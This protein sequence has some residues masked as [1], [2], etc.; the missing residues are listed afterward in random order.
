MYNTGGYGGGVI[1]TLSGDINLLTWK[2][3]THKYTCGLKRLVVERP[4]SSVQWEI[5]TWNT[6]SFRN[7]ETSSGFST[8]LKMFRTIHIEELEV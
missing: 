8:G 4:H 1:F 6:S 3:N 7:L 2:G 5:Q